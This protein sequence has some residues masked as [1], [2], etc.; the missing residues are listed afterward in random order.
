VTERCSSWH[1]PLIRD[2]HTIEY[3]F[4]KSS[5]VLLIDMTACR[6]NHPKRLV[7]IQP[8]RYLSPQILQDEIHAL[9]YPLPSMLSVMPLPRSVGLRSSQSQHLFTLFFRIDN[10]HSSSIDRL[11][12][13]LTP[14]NLVPSSLIFQSSA[15]RLVCFS[16]SRP[17]GLRN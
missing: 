15:V 13:P 6:S 2:S 17:R 7:L 16:L 8:S 11:N 4:P 12:C 9:P 5:Q 14:L 1:F 3:I 10:Y